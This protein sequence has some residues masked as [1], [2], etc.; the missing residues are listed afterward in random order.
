MEHFADLCVIL[1]REPCESF[2]CHFN[3]NMR[4]ARVSTAELFS[5]AVVT[6]DLWNVCSHFSLILGEE[7]CLCSWYGVVR[8]LYIF[9]IQ[10]LYEMQDLQNS[11]LPVC[12]SYF[13]S[14]TGYLL[15]AR[16]GFFFLKFWWSPIYRFGF[17]IFCFGW[18]KISLPD[19]RSQRF[20]PRSLIA[21]GF[22]V[23]SMT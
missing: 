1:P 6:F 8:V 19:S 12:G 3:F 4:A 16:E 11:F 18:P 22:T 10:G 5:E 13:H 15:D 17:L 23:S 9:W 7:G 21:F 20:S 2:L 14:L